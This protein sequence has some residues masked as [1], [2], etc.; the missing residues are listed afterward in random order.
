MPVVFN[1]LTFLVFFVVVLFLH[2]LRLPWSVK[3]VNLLVASYLFYA[4]W[5]PPF[6]LLLWAS[7]AV[8]WAAALQIHRQTDPRRRKFWLILSLIFNLSFLGFFKYGNW[9]Q[10][11]WA[12]LMELIGVA[13]SAP[14]W[15]ILLPIGI[16]FYIF[17][18][19]SYTLDVYWKRV[20]PIPKLFDFALFVAFFTQ[21]VAGPILRTADLVPQFERPRTGTA[22]QLGWG[23]ALM[24]FGLFEKVV[25]ADAVLA[26][27]AD[28]VYGWGEPVNGVDAWVATIS[29]SVQV[30][31]DFAGYSITAI[32]AAMCLGFS[33][34]NNFR[35]PFAAVGVA[36]YWRRWHVSFST[37][38]RDYIYYPLGGSRKGE[39]RT[40]VNLMITLLI[41]GLWHGANWT[42]VVWGGVFGLMLCG[43]RLL[44]RWTKGWRF[45]QGVWFAISMM[46]LTFV[47]VSSMR[48]LF[49][50]TT[51]TE[52]M[53]LF[54]SMVG[55]HSSALPVLSL[56]Q[57]GLSALCI[58]ATLFAH[59]KMRDKELESVVARTPAW[60]VVGALSLMLFLTIIT[61]GNG[62]G[63]I[64][65]QF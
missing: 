5:N 21:L 27:A 43:E 9:L 50:S 24:I 47:L 39:L 36:D 60:I 59:W 22:N 63:F 54:K 48:V 64:Y 28:T 34:P 6:L 12:A 62:D 11:N 52:S 38:L 20:Q 42:F 33:I 35:A 26:P 1:S 57:I 4:A 56:Y 2:N 13:Y 61:Q 49:R 3:K 30:F 51:L 8:D 31:F 45:P 7:T 37:W 53:L 25:L 65:F 44:R 32:G 58:A 46:L 14:K 16:S 18:S 19:M 29:F 15:N 17:H 41:S 40:N 55:L 23:L 10:E